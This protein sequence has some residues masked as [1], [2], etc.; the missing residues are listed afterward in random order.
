M[1]SISMTSPGDAL[2]LLR[3]WLRTKRQRVSWTQRR[4]QQR[5]RSRDRF[6]ERGVRRLGV[7]RVHA[8]PGVSGDRVRDVRRHA[9]ARGPV[10]PYSA[11]PIFGDG[12]A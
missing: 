11:K 7:A 1:D 3:T 12:E 4:L 9:D 2:A 6:A 5:D 10:C 8:A